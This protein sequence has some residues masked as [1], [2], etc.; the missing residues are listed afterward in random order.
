MSHTE[1]SAYRLMAAPKSRRPAASMA[2]R[3]SCTR[4]G[5]A[6]S[7]GTMRS[8]PQRAVTAAL[9]SRASVPKGCPV[10]I[11]LDE[12]RAPGDVREA[13]RQTTARVE[14]SGRGAEVGVPELS[15]YD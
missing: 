14:Q 8:I 10:A 15:L 13:G 1:S 5:V 2:C 4:S 11:E 6:D 12:Q 3:V 7:S 9:R